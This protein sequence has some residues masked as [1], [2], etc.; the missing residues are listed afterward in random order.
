MTRASISLSPPNDNWIQS[1]IENE[2][3]SSRSEV[4]NDLIRKAR[5]QTREREYIIAKLIAA[6]ESEFTDKTGTEMLER[7]KEKARGLGKL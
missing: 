3:F 2:E 5:E 4:V 7:F 6:E 1:Q